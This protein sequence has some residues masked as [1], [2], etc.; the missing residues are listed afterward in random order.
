MSLQGKAK[1]RG[2]AN[3]LQFSANALI[4]EKLLNTLIETDSRETLVIGSNSIESLHESLV[5]D[6]NIE[7]FYT[8]ARNNRHEHVNNVDEEEAKTRIFCLNL[9]KKK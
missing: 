1:P 3:K 9:M 8:P 6:N 2:H 5:L 4:E 7:H